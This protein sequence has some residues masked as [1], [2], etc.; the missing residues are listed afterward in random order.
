M[1]QVT[2]AIVAEK[3]SL[4]NTTAIVILN[5]RAALTWVTGSSPATC[6]TAPLRNATVSAST[7]STFTRNTVHTSVHNAAK[8][9]PSLQASTNTH[10][11][12]AAKDPTSVPIVPKPSLLPPYCA[13]TS[14]NTAERNPSSANIVGVHLHHMQRMTVTC[15]EIIKLIVATGIRLLSSLA[16][17]NLATSILKWL[18]LKNNECKQQLS[19]LTFAQDSSTVFHYID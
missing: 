10:E 16:Y 18:H 4:T 12:T 1:I 11:F 3:F 17:C 2:P 9:S 15:G 19:L 6:A 7:Y 14:V 5:T 8:D 13:R